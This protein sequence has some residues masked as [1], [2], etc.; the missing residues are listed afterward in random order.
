M[1]PPLKRTMGLFNKTS[2]LIVFF[3]CMHVPM[4]E[5]C[6]GRI[7]SDCRNVLN[8]MN[9]LKHQGNTSKQNPSFN[10]HISISS[11]CSREPTVRRGR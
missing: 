5:R 9:K 6:T 3:V 11:S 4:C 8:I 10:V 2:H 7:P 1:F